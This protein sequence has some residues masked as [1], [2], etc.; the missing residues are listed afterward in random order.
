MQRRLLPRAPSWP[1][2]KLWGRNSSSGTPECLGLRLL[3]RTAGIWG[4]GA[5]GVG[6]GHPGIPFLVLEG[7]G[8]GGALGET[9]V[10]EG[11]LRKSL[12]RLFGGTLEWS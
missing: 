3:T 5:A 1:R 8:R 12:S 2:A 11:G 9:T 10:G 6:T 4:L 7:E